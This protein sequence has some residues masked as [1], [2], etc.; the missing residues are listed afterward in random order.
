MPKVLI[1]GFGWSGQSALGFFSA[2][3]F[4]CYVVDDALKPKWTLE[5]RFITKEQALAMDF[6]LYLVCI[7]QDDVAQRV[8]S[9]LHQQEITEE[10][11]KLFQTYEY[12][13]KMSHLLKSMFGN[14]Q[15]ILRSCLQ[16]SCKMPILHSKISAILKLYYQENSTSMQ[17]LAQ[18]G[19]E[20][21]VD[22][23]EQSVFSILCSTS[24]QQRSLSH[25]AYP[26]F[27]VAISK[28]KTV[29]KNFYF[30][31]KINFEAIKNRPKSIKLVACFGNS[32]LRVEYLPIENTITSYLQEILGSNFIVLNF[33]IQ[34]Y[35]LYEQMM[36][37]HA[38]IY[39]LK[40]EIVL[41]FFAGTDF[42]IGRICDVYL[43]KKHQML[44]V[45]YYYE[46]IYKNF[47]MSNLPL[48]CE[49]QEAD[50][51]INDGDIIDSLLAR[52]EQFH[53]QVASVVAAGG[54]ADLLPLSNRYFL[55]N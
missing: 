47:A 6:D 50:A 55:A 53:A 42:R 38:L 25:I 7:M 15:E 40:P 23:D 26:C 51:K 32:A 13:A 36:L 3:G 8:I 39:P 24:L 20:I 41:S 29:D 52:L 10:K 22:F 43:I 16:E 9:M 31:Q 18:K 30:V 46:K 14:A 37:Y 45:P 19:D 17:A 48:Y 34:G 35:T 1:Y 28:D 2:L 4:E 44:Y 21:R 12:Q 5:T 11:I 27:N 33:G 49:T 54:G